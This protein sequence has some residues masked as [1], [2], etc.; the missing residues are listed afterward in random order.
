[1]KKYNQNIN[2]TLELSE[3]MIRIAVQGE[4]SSEDS[5]CWVLYGTILDSAYKIK[6]L[7]EKE[8]KSHQDGGKW[9]DDDN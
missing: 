4:A 9:D 2:K 3:K 7:A 6:Q 8:K 5:G 1:M